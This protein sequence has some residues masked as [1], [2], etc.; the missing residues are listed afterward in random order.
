MLKRINLLYIML[1]PLCY[2]LWQ[3]N[4][5]LSQTSPFF[6]GF[7]ENK[8]TELSHY[9]PV[10]VEKIHVTPGQEVVKGQLLL[11]VKHSNIDFKIGAAGNDIKR[12]NIISQQEKIILKS[13]INELELR[14]ETEISENLVEKRNLELSIQS[15][16]DLLKGLKSFENVP[17]N[18]NSSDALKL[19]AL[20]K[21]LE[22][23]LAPITLEIEQLK[24]QLKNSR[25]P[26]E[27]RRQS[28]KEE[29]DY[30]KKEQNKLSI[31]AP[32]DGLIGNVLCKVEENINQFSTMINFY[33]RYPTLVK[34]YVHESLI[35]E[36]KVDDSLVVSSAMHPQHKVN[37]IVVG[38]GTRIVEIP[39]R[40]R[41]MPDFKT[42]GREVLIRI[43]S[44]NP[45]LQKEKVMLNSLN[46]AENGSLS[47]MLTPFTGQNK[48]EEKRINKS[49][50]NN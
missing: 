40:L 6:Y 17:S 33:E 24:S 41:K 9:E 30:L 28:L 19:A 12:L 18:P 7:A 5:G 44:E 42:Y 3:M 16:N 35:L 46:E 8:E 27:V 36:V 10:T 29:I 25:S 45:F 13:K 32:S 11:E 23:T 38:M 31:H 34:G 48:K 39:E 50:E 49:F 15:K 20:D 26:E 37:G 22:L 14:K 43:P 47:F 1:I 2:F 4:L 21:K